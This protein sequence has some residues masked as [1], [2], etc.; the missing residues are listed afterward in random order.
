M[1]FHGGP[2][3]EDL[4]APFNKKCV[5]ALDRMEADQKSVSFRE[6]IDPPAALLFFVREAYNIETRIYPNN[7]SI[8]GKKATARFCGLGYFAR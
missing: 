7:R 1:L 5:Y 6:M 4:L 2:T 3:E 8:I